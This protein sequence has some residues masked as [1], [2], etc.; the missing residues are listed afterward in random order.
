MDSATYANLDQSSI[1]SSSPE[2][3]FAS[4]AIFS[5]FDSTVVGVSVVSSITRVL[6]L[7]KRGK[8]DLVPPPDLAS[9]NNAEDRR[10]SL[11]HGC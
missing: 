11:C 2:S 8:S 9:C 6:E 5:A 10:M 7:S 4:E 1:S 3:T